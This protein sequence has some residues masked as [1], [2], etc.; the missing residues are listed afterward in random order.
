MKK[1]DANER[2]ALRAIMDDVLRPFVPE[3]KKVVEQED[4]SILLIKTF[5]WCYVMHAVT[6]VRSHAITGTSLSCPL[7]ATLRGFCLSRL[8]GRVLLVRYPCFL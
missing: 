2:N 8:S 1:S 4:G 3:F 7:M 5:L 6:H